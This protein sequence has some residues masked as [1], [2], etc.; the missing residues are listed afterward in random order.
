[1]SLDQ[2]QKKRK[3]YENLSKVGTEMKIIQ[4][5]SSEAGFY[6]IWPDLG[7]SRPAQKHQKLVKK[8]VEKTAKK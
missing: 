4:K 1:M 7:V 2:R 5:T 8:Q 6:Q 3:I